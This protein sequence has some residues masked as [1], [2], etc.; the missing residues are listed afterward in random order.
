M[1]CSK[2][3]LETF[4]KI[5]QAILL[6]FL[7]LFIVS[8]FVNMGLSVIWLGIFLAFYVAYLIFEFC[9][10]TCKF[11][12]NKTHN[13]GLKQIL[14]NLFK[15]GPVFTL[16]CECYHYEVHTVRVRASPPRK[17][18]GKSRGGGGKKSSKKPAAR[19]TGGTKS[20]GTHKLVHR[21]GG[22]KTS[23]APRYRTKTVRK[24]V[25]THRETVRFPYI[26]SRDISGAFKL[27]C[28]RDQAMGKSYVKLEL[29]HS[30]A[31]A[32][33]ET[34]ADYQNF[35][36]NFYNRNRGRDQ[37]MSFS[38]NKYIP[39]FE[40]YIFVCIRNVEP[41]GINVGLFVLFTIIPVVELYKSYVNSYC[42][43][44][45][46]TIKKVVSTR[47]NL[48]NN[49]KYDSLKPTIDI[50]SE[51]YNFEENE[52]MY[53]YN[54]QEMEKIQPNVIDNMG[55]NNYKYNPNQTPMTNQQQ[56]SPNINNMNMNNIDM[57]NNMNMNNNIDMYNNMNNNMNMNM[58]N[59]MNNNM[60]MNM[61]NN[62]NNNMNMNNNI[63]MNNNMNNNM[64]MNNNID[65]TNNISYN[66][67]NNP[68]PYVEINVNNNVNIDSKNAINVENNNISDEEDDEDDDDENNGADAP[69]LG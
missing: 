39:N 45:T 57:N 17:G 22:G 56:G 30:I 51:Q 32:D 15:T 53:Q 61:N 9:S 28:E 44:Q 10:P 69:Y 58:N 59:N 29:N 52:Y 46:F 34:Q 60:N 42:I 66:V 47:E 7:A 16:H 33:N 67:N 11:L 14:G 41:C 13:E 27:N 1:C 6:I 4:N 5:L 21:T 23:H 12:C 20:K 37:E 49:P 68:A 2:E 55:M 25:V 54:N 36:T 3:C 64:N 31:F 18:G 8:F 62:M 43:D 65:M 63:D 35:K 40:N 26:S 50:P 38:E 48:N 19:H 24:K